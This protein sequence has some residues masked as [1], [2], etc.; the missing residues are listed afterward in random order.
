MRPQRKRFKR[1]AVA[2]LLRGAALGLN[3]L[4]PPWAHALGAAAGRAFG[5]AGALWDQPD[6]ARAQA[7]LSR[8]LGLEAAQAAAMTREVF[9]QLGR[10]GAELATMRPD[11]IREQVRLP[12]AAE[13]VLRQAREAGPV[14][15]VAG[16]LGNWEL[17]A[18][19]L[20]PVLT[21]CAVLAT[22]PPNPGI[23]RWLEARRRR[24]GVLTVAR[25]G[26]GTGVLRQVLRHRGGVGVLLDQRTLV[27]SVDVPF[28]GV[29]APTPIRPAQW[30]IRRRLAVVAAV[31][32]R[33]PSGGFRVHLEP[34]PRGGDPVDLTRRLTAWLEARI[35]EHP[36][37][38]VWVHDRW[39]PS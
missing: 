13:Q 6:R 18:A 10:F 34:I 1:M 12:E 11:R 30:A 35:R 15:V 5:F 32:V 16:H 29:P 14:L 27:P 37:Q 26:G 21:P 39:T 17:L 20:A 33:E 2:S 7:Q 8:H 22:D 24:F 36:E 19:R 23:G 31:C 25:G 38:W 28:F 9:A 4:P 3:A